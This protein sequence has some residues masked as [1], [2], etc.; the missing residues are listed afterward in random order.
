MWDP[1]NRGNLYTI[2]GNSP[3]S[4][5]DPLGLSCIRGDFKS[6]MWAAVTE[7]FSMDTQVDSWQAGGWSL[8]NAATFHQSESIKAGL[9]GSQDDLGLS[10]G[11]KRL[12][13]ATGDLTF[14]LVVG[15]ATGG[16]S[17]W[18]LSGA[19]ARTSA[20]YGGVMTLGA[21]ATGWAGGVLTTTGIREAADGDPAHGQ[22]HFNDGLTLLFP[23]PGS[24]GA[25]A[26]APPGPRPGSVLFGSS[27]AA[28]P[29]YVPLIQGGRVGE[30]L[31]GSPGM[32]LGKHR[33][34]D[35]ALQLL[36]AKHN[37]E[38]SLLY[39]LGPGNNGGGGN[40]ILYSGSAGAVDF[41]VAPGYIWISHTHPAGDALKPS[42][43]D[44]STL[45]L[46]QALGSKQ[47]TSKI[48]PIDGTPFHF[49]GET[50]VPR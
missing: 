25:T 16:S 38:F 4:F 43:Q 40:Y 2:G 46:L 3:Y 36:A 18:A 1:S 13:N 45:R 44:V 8:L 31:P 50:T 11:D 41:P 23:G 34:P 26:L 5:S 27:G 12:A 42:D 24:V 20:F 35:E 9:S 19:A 48:I 17:A 29:G 14:A 32:D 15:A 28:A 10:S 21:T 47:R 33:P 6:P 49:S 7:F 30:G 39:K 37:V 22:A